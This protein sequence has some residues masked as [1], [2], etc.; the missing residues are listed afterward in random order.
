MGLGLPA[1]PPSLTHTHTASL[2]PSLA[3]LSLSS[4]LSGWIRSS[5]ACNCAPASERAI[6][7]CR[8]RDLSSPP[9]HR[10]LQLQPPPAFLATRFQCKHSQ[11]KC[12]H[13]TE[14]TERQRR[15]RRRQKKKKQQQ[16]RNRQMSSQSLDHSQTFGTSFHS[17]IEFLPRKNLTVEQC[18]A[19]ILSEQTT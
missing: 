7:C 3:P 14:L 19:W 9:D 8:Q 18:M 11:G 2:T 15:R 12:P 10:G 16:M 17:C 5:T 6:H 13:K 1:S 4:P